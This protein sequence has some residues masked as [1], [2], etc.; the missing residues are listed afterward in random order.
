MCGH[1]AEEHA[2][3]IRETLARLNV[4]IDMD[5]AEAIAEARMELDQ[6]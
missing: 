3:E 2:A 1:T 4:V 6:L 5:E